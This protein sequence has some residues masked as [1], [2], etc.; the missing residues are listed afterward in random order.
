MPSENEYYTKII[1]TI[2]EE[3]KI[4]LDIFES[5][6][7]FQKQNNYKAKDLLSIFFI[8]ILKIL[9]NVQKKIVAH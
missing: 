1:K 7:K 3:K 6:N 5:L 9:T 8:D 2:N 4:S